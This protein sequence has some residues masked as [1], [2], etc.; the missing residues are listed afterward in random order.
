MSSWESASCTRLIEAISTNKRDT[1]I[2]YI[3]PSLDLWESHLDSRVFSRDAVSFVGKSRLLKDKHAS[4]GHAY[5]TEGRLPQRRGPGSID[6][7]LGPGPGIDL[8]FD[9]E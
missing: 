4:Y 8:N 5:I 7:D 9:R 2:R 6:E 1:I 3:G